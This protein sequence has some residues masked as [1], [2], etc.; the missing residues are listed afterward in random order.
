MNIY[1][2]AQ[3][4][5]YLKRLLENDILLRNIYIEAEISNFKAHG[6]GH[7]Y[8]TLKDSDAAISGVMFKSYTQNIKFKPE[9]GMKVLAGG[10]ISI[11]E[12]TGQYQLYINS[13][14]PAGKGALYLAYEQ[15]K[16]RLEK[17][18]VFD[19]KYKK[20]IP[21]FPKCVAVI[22]SP[23]GA[24]IRDIIN[25][26]GRRNSNVEIV[27]VP[28]LVQGENAAEDVS[29]A[30]DMVNR[31]NKADTIIV[32]RGGGSIEDLWAF[33]EEIVARAIFNSKIPVISAVGHET[34]FTIADFISDLRAPTP[35]AAAELAIPENQTVSSSVLDIRNRLDK[36]IN[37]IISEYRYKYNI[38]TNSYAFKNFGDKIFNNQI[39]IE[40][41]F[42]RLEKSI[43]NTI[44]TNRL[45]LQNLCDNLE[46]KSPL[47]IL[48]KGYS[49]VYTNDK[50]VKSVNDVNY[51]DNIEIALS[52]G[53]IN[54]K[55]IE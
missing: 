26:S 23:T 24:A 20:P 43:N 10:Y 6:S 47:N 39:Y 49:L 27:V 52:D 2:V 30:I 48:K 1:T 53:K 31:W 3:I 44:D 11:Y 35:S 41:L 8:M 5:N 38:I 18:G 51:N 12:K 37:A 34:D 16:A 21:K 29:K 54:A 13:L 4:N 42:N 7:Y 45:R 22:T 36:R 9:N 17:S 15:L 50:I 25:I 19:D 14:E 55:V 32:G 46:N 33:N 28:V 40:D